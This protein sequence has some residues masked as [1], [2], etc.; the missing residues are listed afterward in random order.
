MILGELFH[1]KLW[2]KLSLACRKRRGVFSSVTN[3]AGKSLSSRRRPRTGVDFASC[4]GSGS[5]KAL[6]GPH[7]LLRRSSPSRIFYRPR[8]VD[9]NLYYQRFKKE[10]L[11][12]LLSGGYPM[13]SVMTSFSPLRDKSAPARSA[14]TVRESC[15]SCPPPLR[16][17]KFRPSGCGGHK[18]LENVAT[19]SKFLGREEKPRLRAGITGKTSPP[20]N[21]NQTRSIGTPNVD[22]VVFRTA[23]S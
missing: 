11:D 7:D 10:Y 17:G 1:Q 16:G 19:F 3:R 12:N 21:P 5:V 20:R 14:R 13:L 8:P 22:R 15:T 4:S 23:I 18:N 9:G 2:I 6:R